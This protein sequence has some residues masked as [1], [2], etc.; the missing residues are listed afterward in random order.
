MVYILKTAAAR[1]LFKKVGFSVKMFDLS[2]G[3]LSPILC[4]SRINNKVCLV[5]PPLSLNRRY[6]HLG[7]AAG[8]E[9]PL[10]L[11]YLASILGVEGFEVNII[12]AQALRLNQDETAKMIMGIR[13][14][15]LGISASTMAINSASKLADQIKELN[16][17]IKIIV[18]G[19]HVSA[20]P[21][22]TLLEFDSFDIGVAG[23][24]EDTFK[25]LLLALNNNTDISCI[26]GIARR[27]DGAVYVS[28]PRSRIKNLDTLPYPA[29][30][31]LPDINRFYRLP[32]QSLLG[33]NSFSLVTSRGCLG[34]CSFCDKKFSVII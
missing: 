12:D 20:R 28:R 15:Y 6:G 31:L 23:E 22:E 34:R 18:G 8:C 9:P 13:P 1:A 25:E 3:Y 21:V 26:D 7:Q 32:S 30:N 10:G 24:G 27:E 2:K 5:V 16:Q 14:R 11:C 17:D 19:C 4:M 29:F 33:R